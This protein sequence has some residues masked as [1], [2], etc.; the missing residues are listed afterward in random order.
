MSDVLLAAE[1]TVELVFAENAADVIVQDAATTT[2]VEA[3]NTTVVVTVSPLPVEVIS[4]DDTAHV[5]ETAAAQ[6]P[7]GPVTSE[8]FDLDLNA[9]YQIAK[10]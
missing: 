10:L 1:P 6:G 5:I 9:I 2:I 3:N 7:P 8:A 4:T